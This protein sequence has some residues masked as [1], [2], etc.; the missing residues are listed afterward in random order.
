MSSNY[1][2]LR[3][4]LYLEVSGVTLFRIEATKTIKKLEVKKG[5]IGGYVEKESNLSGDAGVCG[6]ARVYGDAQVYGDKVKACSDCINLINTKYN[7]TILPG[8]LKIGCQY[9]SKN[10][11]WNFTDREILQ[12]DGKDGLKWWKEWKPILAA[13]CE[14][15]R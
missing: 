1:Y 6:N 9:H 12:M 10:E 3:K 14:T 2:K 15:N 5:D 4:D 11:W 7:V 13:I 8:H